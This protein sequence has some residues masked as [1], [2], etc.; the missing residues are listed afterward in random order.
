MSDKEKVIECLN[1]VLNGFETNKDIDLDDINF[2]NNN[3]D[4]LKECNKETLRNFINNML[5]QDNIGLSM[6]VLTKSGI[7][8]LSFPELEK[9]VDLEQPSKYH[10][11]DAFKHTVEAVKYSEK[12]L[13]LRLTMLLHDVGKFETFNKDEL[14]K[15]T[16]Y[17]HGDKGEKLASKMLVRL[18][19]DK[20][21]INEIGLDVKHHM[22]YAPT[23]KSFAKMLKELG[24]DINK[25]DK[26]LKV[27]LYDKYA[28][29]GMEGEQVKSSQEEDLAFRK[30]M[31]KYKR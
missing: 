27:K 3:I 7:L 17:G 2:I 5:L 19:Y 13:V 1:R 30:L 14:G 26:L 4:V 28:C 9:L 8:F 25:V 21:M 31:D 29:R 15:I 23:E 16:F 11:Y 20:K 18:G 22:D 10:D 24:N 6:K 12:D